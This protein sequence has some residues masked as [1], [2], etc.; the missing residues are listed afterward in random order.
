[1]LGV[2][3]MQGLKYIPI[4]AGRTS[5]L[6]GKC[7]PVATIIINFT[8]VFFY[9]KYYTKILRKSN[10]PKVLVLLWFSIWPLVVLMTINQPW[11]VI[12]VCTYYLI[13]IPSKSKEIH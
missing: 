13:R 7:I 6:A 2:Y 12:S 5:M 8:T 4:V 9:P 1:M 11:V 10:F 3:T